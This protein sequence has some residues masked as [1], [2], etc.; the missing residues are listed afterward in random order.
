MNLSIDIGGTKIRFAL[1]KDNQVV[2]SSEF[3][4]NVKNYKENILK[5]KTTFDQW[6]E[7]VEFIGI[8]CPGPLDIKSGK[9]YNS[10]NL[11]DWNNKNLKEEFGSVFQVWDIRI[12]NDANVAALGQFNVRHD[13]HSLLYFTI[14]TGIG[15]G[16]IID[17]KIYNGFTGTA[18]EIANSFPDLDFGTA[19]SG[20]EYFAS[21]KNIALKLQSLG[22]SVKDT[23]TAFEMYYAKTNQIVNEYFAKIKQKLVVMFA[24][25]IYFLNPEIVVVGGSVAMHNQEWFEEIF[26]EVIKVTQDINYQTKFEFAK[27]L[28]ES[29]FIGCANL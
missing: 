21:G 28:D 12:N 9:I 11:E 22:V 7:K 8:A 16:M 29:T 14:S 3:F 17:Q 1:V 5:I 23:K 15:C 25:A 13:L 2:K 24:T 10:P 6:A 19:K 4:N 18:C 20:I 26:A 27:D